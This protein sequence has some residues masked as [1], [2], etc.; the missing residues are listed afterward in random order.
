MLQIRLSRGP[1]GDGGGSSGAIGGGAGFGGGAKSTSTVVD[2]V[3][4]ACPDHLILADLPVAKGLGSLSSSVS[5]IKSI[6]RRSRRQLGERIHFCV[7]C[8]FPI[9]IYGRLAPCEHSFCLACA[10][11]DSTCYLCDERIQKI[12]TIKMMEGIFI[13]A[14]PHC[15]KSF[16]KRSEF[17][18]HVHEIH[19]DLLQTNAEKE[20]GSEA[21]GLNAPRPTSLDI[22]AKQSAPPES[23]TGRSQPR[24]GYSPN[25]SSQQQDREDKARRHQPRESPSPRPPMQPPLYG[26]Q[27]YQQPESQADNN[28]QQSIDRS[29]DR[30]PIPQNF[31]IQGRRDSDLF[32]DR[33]GGTSL[34]G[35]PSESP[36][37]DY[38]VQ[39]HQ[40]PNF[41]VPVN[42]NPGPNIPPGFG[43]P[44]FMEG[45]QP[46]YSTQYEVGRMELAS[47][48]AEREQG[49]LLTTPPTPLPGGIAS[50]Q[51]GYPR[52]WPVGSM[53]MSLDGVPSS[54]GNQEGRV[55]FSQGEYGSIPEGLPVNPLHPP[56]GKETGSGWD[57]RS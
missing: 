55:H 31:E 44:P 14:A 56:M 10:R 16:L 11:S 33:H 18:V 40:P 17:E 3:T 20:V 51:D 15:L 54:Q 6:G 46:Y 57:C 7:R 28:T 23:S 19:A 29:Y 5:S 39:S 22:Y 37:P 52:Q 25:S 4:V 13:C 42:M 48:G 30:A 2:G 26:Q 21:D 47:E 35:T 50:F 38:A 36:F 49:P 1:S 41:V 53:G 24:P 8:D 34:G 9:A 45:S 12:Q 43:Y 32:P 27:L